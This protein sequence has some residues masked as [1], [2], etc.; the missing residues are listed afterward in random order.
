MPQPK[1]KLKPVLV[2]WYDATSTDRW[3]TRDLLDKLESIP[4]LTMGW[5]YKKTK[6]DIIIINS[7][8]IHDGQLEHIH[9]F[10]IPKAWAQITYLPEECFN[11]DNQGHGSA[12]TANKTDS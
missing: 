5:L 8:D 11:E 10:V 2:C 7:V 12:G 4:V 9:R 1:L 6:R 3:G